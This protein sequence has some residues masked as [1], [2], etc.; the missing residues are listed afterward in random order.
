MSLIFPGW[1]S[2]FGN[3]EFRSIAED[4]VIEQKPA[5][6]Y[7]NS[8]WLEPDELRTFQELYGA[9]QKTM[10]ES[11][12]GK[13]ENKYMIIAELANYLYSKSRLEN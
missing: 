8:F 3:P 11:K 10:K 5:N 1:T 2:R 4:I 9:W 6:V 13:E 7:A 12:S